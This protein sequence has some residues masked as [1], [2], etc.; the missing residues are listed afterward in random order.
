M[1][2]LALRIIANNFCKGISR[3]VV[4]TCKENIKVCTG[5]CSIN[6]FNSGLLLFS[7]KLKFGYYK[8]LEK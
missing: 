4:N 5:S 3:I 7:N 8:C 6:I 1:K 2:S